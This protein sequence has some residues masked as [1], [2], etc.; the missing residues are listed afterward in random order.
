MH[1][2]E[3]QH[4]LAAPGCFLSAQVNPNKHLKAKTLTSIIPDEKSGCTML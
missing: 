3:Q 1:N 2:E 4:F